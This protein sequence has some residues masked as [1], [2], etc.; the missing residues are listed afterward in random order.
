MTLPAEIAYWNRGMRNVVDMTGARN[1][2]DG[3]DLVGLCHAFGIPLP[4]RSVLDVGCGTGRLSRHCDGY[5]GADIAQSAVD[6]CRAAGL[7][8]ELIDE[9]GVLPIGPFSWTLCISVFTHIDR[10]ARQRY[11]KAFTAP[12]LIADIIPGD[13]TGTMEIW[14]ATPEGFEAD[15][16]HAG[17]AIHGWQERVWEDAGWA[18]YHA[19]KSNVHRYYHAERVK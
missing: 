19:S 2:M 3:A 12:R 8:A 18:A 4:L 14:S 6:Y 7:H 5:V 9:S 16:K 11:L 17:F 13:E 1:L 15:L 10:A